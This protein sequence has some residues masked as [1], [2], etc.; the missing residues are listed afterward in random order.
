MLAKNSRQKRPDQPLLDVAKLVVQMLWR[1]VVIGAYGEQFD[2]G[3][4]RS[5][6]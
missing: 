1:V 5:G 6:S 4:L 2:P 3:S